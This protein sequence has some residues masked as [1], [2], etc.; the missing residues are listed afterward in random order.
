MTIKLDIE[1]YIDP[2]T[3]ILFYIIN[4]IKL[5]KKEELPKRYLFNSPYIYFDEDINK[6]IS[7]RYGNLDI[8]KLGIPE[9][10]FDNFMLFLEKC[11]KNYH[12]FKKE[13]ENWLKNHKYSIE[14][15]E[16]STKVKYYITDK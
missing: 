8:V 11:V 1:K 14:L 4:S 6:I 10:A 12:K 3:Q 16:N 2:E 15:F 7:S 9:K 5:K 13:E